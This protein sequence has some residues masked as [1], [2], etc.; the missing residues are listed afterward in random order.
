MKRGSR[1][2]THSVSTVL[3]VNC[4]SKEDDDMT[5]LLAQLRYEI[6]DRRDLSRLLR[7]ALRHLHSSRSLLIN[8]KA[9]NKRLIVVLHDDVVL[10]EEIVLERLLYLKETAKKYM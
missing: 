6:S 10:L 1:K 2:S 5:R 7:L 9:Y 3:P 8:F 4:L